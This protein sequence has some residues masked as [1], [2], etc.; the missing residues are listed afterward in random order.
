MEKR[1]GHRIESIQ[2]L[3]APGPEKSLAVFE[4]RSDE[5]AAEA[6]GNSRF[7]DEDFE[8]VTVVAVQAELGAEPQEPPVIL[9]DLRDLGLGEAIGCGKMSEPDIGSIDNR[10]VDLSKTH[11]GLRHCLCRFEGGSDRASRQTAINA[12]IQT[13]AE[14]SSLTS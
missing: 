4:K 13:K 12:R 8:I 3:I 1:L 6:G 9:N 5:N 2:R 14:T 7:V 11:G 10:H